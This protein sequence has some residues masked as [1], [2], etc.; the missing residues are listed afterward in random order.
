MFDDIFD[1][2][3]AKISIS[4][5]RIIRNEG[6]MELKFAIEAVE[7]CIVSFTFLPEHIFPDLGK[8]GLISRMQ[9]IGSPKKLDKEDVKQLAGAEPKIL[10]YECLLGIFRA[11]GF[12]YAVAVSAECQVTYKES[13][14]QAFFNSYDKFFALR[15]FQALRDGFLK[16]DME[17][18]GEVN[19]SLS[20]SHR[21]RAERRREIRADFRDLAY[22]GWM[23]WRRQASDLGAT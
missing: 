10:L 6:E 5:A 13:F 8:T 16:L 2:Y 3:N 20:L 7:I 11:M 14:Y 22:R 19:Q 1:K 21:K 23:A 9:Y 18:G 15:G 4:C 12:R 17:A